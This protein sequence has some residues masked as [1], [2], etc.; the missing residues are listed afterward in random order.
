[1]PEAHT[2]PSQ[3]PLENRAN[4][5]VI[6]FDNVS[7]CYN[8][9]SVK[10][11]SFK[12]YIIERIRRRVRYRKLWA[13]RNINLTV[14]RGEVMGVI[15]PNGA[16][17]STLLQVVARILKPTEGRVWVKG[18]VAP[19]LG[20]GAGFHPE[21]TGR[22]NVF[23]NGTLLGF[24]RPKM[25]EKFDRIVDFA[26]LW[27]FIDAPLR[28]YSSG[29]RTRLGFAVATDTQPDVLIIDEV[30]GVGDADFREKSTARMR[31]FFESG[32]TILLVTHS[33]GTVR[34]LCHRATWLHKGEVRMV[35]KS[36][37]VVKGYMSSRKKD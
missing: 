20:I 4:S 12:G 19:L 34:E 18:Q 21:L 14:N 15:G 16:G 11:R 8:L 25:E 24:S 1:M 30:L 26:E 6:R 29:M 36:K 32:T 35:G 3:T 22:E 10:L 33:M 7:V 5:E 13:L 28:T 31:E 27:D 17:K 23:L 2:H 37:K 9:P